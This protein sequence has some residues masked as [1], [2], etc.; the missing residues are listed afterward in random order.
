MKQNIN[1]N[2]KDFSSNDALNE[3]LKEIEKKFG[4]KCFLNQFL[5]KMQVNYEKSL[6]MFVER[7]I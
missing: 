6:K 3:A 5:E 2:T 4:K 1:K 7:N